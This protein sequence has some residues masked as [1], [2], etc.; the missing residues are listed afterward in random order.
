MRMK[1]VHKCEPILCEL[2]FCFFSFVSNFCF[3]FFSSTCTHFRL[4]R[5]HCFTHT[6]YYHA[7]AP[8]LLL[9]YSFYNNIYSIHFHLRLAR[10]PTRSRV[11]ARCSLLSFNLVSVGRVTKRNEID[12][13]KREKKSKIVCDRSQCPIMCG[14]LAGNF[15]IQ[16]ELK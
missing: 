14:W 12:W 6:A 4:L 16:L 7:C 15:C 9:N 2:F 11:C 10:L 3:S 5:S 1:H 13:E 8:T